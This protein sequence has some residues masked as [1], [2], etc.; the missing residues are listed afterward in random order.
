MSPPNNTSNASAP[1]VKTGEGVL[2]LEFLQKTREAFLAE[3]RFR[4]AKNAVSRSDPLEVL[5]EKEVKDS[6]THSYTHR[7]SD[8]ECKATAQKAS[9]RCWLFAALNVM[10]LAMT[11]KYKLPDDFQLSQSYLFFWDKIERS[12]YFL[13]SILETANE[14]VD[15]RLVSWLLTAPVQDG[16]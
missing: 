4:L 13:E 3:P 9:G 14:P 15:G 5:L 2:S 8:H 12:N 6:N 10:R 7:V 1:I 11:S 16:G